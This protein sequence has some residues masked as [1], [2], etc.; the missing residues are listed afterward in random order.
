MIFQKTNQS[1]KIEL[2]IK[3]QKVLL[4]EISKETNECLFGHF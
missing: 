1:Q 2:L 4:E 3:L